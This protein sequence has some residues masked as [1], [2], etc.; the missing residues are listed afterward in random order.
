MRRIKKGIGVHRR[1]GG[2]IESMENR[3]ES[4][5]LTWK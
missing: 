4:K 1:R 3:K 2:K 5:H